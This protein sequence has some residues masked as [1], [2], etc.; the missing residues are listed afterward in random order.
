[1]CKAVMCSKGLVGDEL[2]LFLKE[3][4][5]DTFYRPIMVHVSFLYIPICVRLVCTRRWDSVKQL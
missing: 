3:G 4:G 1:M 5:L 2:P